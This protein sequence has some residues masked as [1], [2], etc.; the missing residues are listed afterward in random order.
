MNI[1]PRRR[2]HR[3]LSLVI[4]TVIFSFF[5]IVLLYGATDF[6][7]NIFSNTWYLDQQEKPPFFL[8]TRNKLAIEYGFVWILLSVI[9]KISRKNWDRDQS[10]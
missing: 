7:Q 10:N 2:T 9:D 1:R 3:I 5:G 8:I 4:Y 6:I